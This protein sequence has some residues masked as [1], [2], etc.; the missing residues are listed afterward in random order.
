MT[1]ITRNFRTTIVAAL[2]AAAVLPA[3]AQERWKPTRPIT[4]IAPNAPGGTSDRTARDLQ[5]LLQKH[6][7]VEVGMVKTAEDRK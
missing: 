4:L 7:L 2:I 1:G 3:F 6:K 5:R